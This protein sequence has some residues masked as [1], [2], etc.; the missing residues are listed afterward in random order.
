M[1]VWLQMIR[2]EMETAANHSYFKLPA[3]TRRVNS[4]HAHPEYTAVMLIAYRLA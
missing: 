2:R 3:Q 1:V 4:A